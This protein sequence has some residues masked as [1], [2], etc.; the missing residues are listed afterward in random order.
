M[1]ITAKHVLYFSYFAVLLT[2]IVVLYLRFVKGI[3]ISKD[4][5]NTLIMGTISLTLIVIPILTSTVKLDV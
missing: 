3:D 1:V 4:Y 2:D 5:V